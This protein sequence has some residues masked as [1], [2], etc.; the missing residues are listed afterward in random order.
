MRDEQNHPARPVGV[1]TNG[2]TD[3]VVQPGQSVQILLI[4]PPKGQYSLICADHDWDGMV[5]SIAVD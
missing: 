1:A 4:A 3:L 2:G 5:G